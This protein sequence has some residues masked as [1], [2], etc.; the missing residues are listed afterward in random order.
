MMERLP[1]ERCLLSET[2]AH[3]HLVS[4]ETHRTPAQDFS[5]SALRSSLWLWDREPQNTELDTAGL[6]AFGMAFLGCSMR[7][8]GGQRKACA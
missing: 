5:W 7:D 4:L 2:H 8:L 3:A 6:Q 1:L